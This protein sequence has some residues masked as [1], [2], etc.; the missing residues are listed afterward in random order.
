[1]EWLLILCLKGT[2]MWA[3]CVQITTR[4]V[5]EEQCK[6]AATT[7]PNVDGYCIS[8]SGAFLVIKK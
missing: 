6:I 3:G 8:P 7:I 1:M 2:S 5:T 4:M